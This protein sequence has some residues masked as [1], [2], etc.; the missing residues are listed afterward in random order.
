MNYFN[1]HFGNF[2]A[3]DEAGGG[4][5]RITFQSADFSA[6]QTA[7]PDLIQLLLPMP[8]L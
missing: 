6:S 5:K 2:L 1:L 7:Q 8:V 3:L 4:G